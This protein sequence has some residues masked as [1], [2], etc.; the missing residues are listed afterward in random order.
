[1]KAKYEAKM[2]ESG[3]GQGY[4]VV[5]NT[6]TGVWYGGLHTGERDAID[7]ARELNAK[8]ARKAEALRNI[9]LQGLDW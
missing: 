7:T 9:E 3:Y 5:V 8:E 4:F 1:M 6:T 2:I